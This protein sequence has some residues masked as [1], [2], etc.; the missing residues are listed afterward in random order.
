VTLYHEL[1]GD[2]TLGV[3]TRQSSDVHGDMADFLDQ[4]ERMSG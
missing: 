1:T 3:A 2:R 4:L